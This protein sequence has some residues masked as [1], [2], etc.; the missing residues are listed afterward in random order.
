MRHRI[1]LYFITI[2]FQFIFIPLCLAAT[3]NLDELRSF[4]LPG[5]TYLNS[6]LHV[7]RSICRRAERELIALSRE[8]KVEPEIIHYLNRL[9]DLF[10]AM[11]RFE[12][13]EK[14]TP[15]YLWTPGRLTKS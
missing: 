12:S 7:C 5:G 3:E 9:S 10:F 1:L 14:K 15:E 13:C 11:A 4:V 2:L 6:L 8:E